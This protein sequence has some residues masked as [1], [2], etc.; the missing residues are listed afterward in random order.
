MPQGTESVVIR[1]PDVP[2]RT[3]DPT[4]GMVVGTLERC[5][6]WPRGSTEDA[7]RGIVGIEGFH[8][9]A[10]APYAVT[11]EASDVVIVRGDV[12]NIE[13]TPGDWRSRRGK[14]R[15]LLFEVGRY[16]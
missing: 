3:G 6:V 11:P 7:D 12:Y 8:V 15:G 16:A 2:S 10:P 9:W 1:R 14:K 5:I 13:G 4:P